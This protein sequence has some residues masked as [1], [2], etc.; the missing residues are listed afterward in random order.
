MLTLSVNTGLLPQADVV[1]AYRTAA[2]GSASHLSA[3]ATGNANDL[4]LTSRLTH[5]RTNPPR[6]LKPSL[7]ACH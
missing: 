3:T 5:T 2:V 1:L 4:H 7:S 6:I